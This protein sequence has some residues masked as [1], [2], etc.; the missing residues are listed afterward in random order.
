MQKITERK[1]LIAVLIVI[2]LVAVIL[3]LRYILREKSTIFIEME[4]CNLDRLGNV[5]DCGNLEKWRLD[6][7]NAGMKIYSGNEVIGE[8]IY[9]IVDF[10][11]DKRDRGG[12][13]VILRLDS[14]IGGDG[15]YLVA[16]ELTRV[17]KSLVLDIG[18]GDL[19]GV[20]TKIAEDIKPEYKEIQ[21]KLILYGAHPETYDFIKINNN[22]MKSSE[23]Y[24]VAVETEDGNLY[25]RE[26]P[27]YIN[28]I[29]DITLT[30]ELLEGDLYYEGQL[31]K[32]GRT[33]KYVNDDLEVIGKI[34]DVENA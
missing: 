29:L 22:L 6:S 15:E 25:L 5:I 28:I 27:I 9:Y 24:E 26:H 14:V 19:I 2:F 18:K 31:I 30:A 7:F 32:Q 21:I 13:R 1:I 4:L 20:V 12:A 3:G 8:L 23:P 16:G 10:S 33:L 17:G 11:G 34:L